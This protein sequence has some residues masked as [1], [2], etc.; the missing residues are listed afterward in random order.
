MLIVR[1]SS[2][3]RSWAPDVFFLRVSQFVS[4]VLLAIDT[5]LG[6]QSVSFSGNQ[7]VLAVDTGNTRV[8]KVAPG[9][10]ADCSTGCTQVANGFVGPIGIALD[11]SDVTFVT[12]FPAG[13][14][15]KMRVE[16]L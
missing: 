15:V 5:A 13:Q 1:R 3:V 4:A 6:A 16:F 8:I 12:D 10:S 14:L 9:A 2:P 11:A 7:T